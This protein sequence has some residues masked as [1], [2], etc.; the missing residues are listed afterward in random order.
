[1]SAE[2]WKRVDL[3]GTNGVKRLSTSENA[4]RRRAKRR[5][6]RELKPRDARYDA[7]G[8]GGQVSFVDDLEVLNAE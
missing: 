3:T 1:L 4:V 8:V 5:R 6:K 2:N 7:T